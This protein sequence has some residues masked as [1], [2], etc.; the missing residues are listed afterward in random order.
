MGKVEL[1]GYEATLPNGHTIVV[2]TF[3]STAEE[4]YITG[5]EVRN[6]SVLRESKQLMY[7]KNI[8]FF[9]HENPRIDGEHFDYYV[10]NYLAKKVTL[11]EN[12]RFGLQ[13]ND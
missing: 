12:P 10:L 13:A 6:E 1:V 11:G 7:L 8:Y 4:A 2:A 3:H 5:Y 9:A